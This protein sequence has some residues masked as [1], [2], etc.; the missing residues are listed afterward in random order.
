MIPRLKPL[1]DIEGEQGD[2]RIR[3]P[4]RRSGCWKDPASGAF[5]AVQARPGVPLLRCCS[6]VT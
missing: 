6:E 5:G 1:T 2:P 3:G 4:F